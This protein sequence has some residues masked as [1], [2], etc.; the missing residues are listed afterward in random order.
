MGQVLAAHLGVPGFGALESIYTYMLG[1]VH[2]A[3]NLRAESTT[4]RLKGLGASP[5]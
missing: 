3:S 4:G 5:L 1:V 2:C